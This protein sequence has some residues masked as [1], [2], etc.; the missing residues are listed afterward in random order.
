MQA[1]IENEKNELFSL[2]LEKLGY[3]VDPG[4]KISWINLKENKNPNKAKYSACRCNGKVVLITS[5]NISIEGVI[6]I[7]NFYSLI[8]T[9]IPL[10]LR[11]KIEKEDM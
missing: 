7:I 3:M 6:P 4:T 1:I 10:C 9:N 11:I 8:K 2:C 5:D